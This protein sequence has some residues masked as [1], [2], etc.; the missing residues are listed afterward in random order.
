MR[1]HKLE[2]IHRHHPLSCI[3]RSFA[4]EYVHGNVWAT[5]RVHTT[6]VLQTA[7]EPSYLV[8]HLLAD[9]PPVTERVKLMR[10]NQAPQSQSDNHK[11]FEQ[12]NVRLLV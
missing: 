5:A 6:S 12:S 11:R 10:R 9:M 3:F 7:H 1:T 2:R 4:M 8:K